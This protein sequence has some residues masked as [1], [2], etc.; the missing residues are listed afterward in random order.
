MKL[1]PPGPLQLVDNAEH[2]GVDPKGSRIGEFRR[3]Q[4]ARMD[5]SQNIT[6]KELLEIILDDIDQGRLVDAQ[7]CSVQIVCQA[8]G[9]PD[10]PM[11]LRQFRAKMS[12]PEEIG[13][14]Q[15]AIHAII[16]GWRN[17]V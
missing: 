13:F 15:L 5:T 10:G 4:I 9:D 1:D 3:E 16:Q 17:E 6:V 14:L 7:K 2:H 8:P 12:R 11:V